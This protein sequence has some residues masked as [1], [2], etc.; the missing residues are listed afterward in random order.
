MAL[1]TTLY[2]VSAVLA[3]AGCGGDSGNDVAD[4]P[5]ASGAE[6]VEG[7]GCLGCHALDGEGADGPGSD[8]S[9][10]G[11]RRSE[12]EIRKALVEPPS[13]MPPYTS[14]A[15]RDLDALVTYLASLR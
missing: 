8:L 3:F 1:R 6:L 5:Q 13:S 14:L 12:A 2:A 9:G 11:G 4:R 7:N 15:E 10:I